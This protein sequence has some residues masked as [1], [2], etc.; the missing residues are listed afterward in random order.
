MAKQT[1]SSGAGTA[2]GTR[3]RRAVG[4]AALSVEERAVLNWTTEQRLA[5]FQRVNPNI[6]K[7]LLENKLL[8]IDSMALDN[9]E[10]LEALR[11]NPKV[12]WEIVRDMFTGGAVD[13]YIS[14]FH[15]LEDVNYPEHFWKVI[16]EN[17]R[18]KLVSTGLT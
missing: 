12:T 13:G 10:I 4:H 14:T 3:K 15:G 6:E 16:I 8:F 2:T 5:A 18:Q 17:E 11:V 1:Q 7:R 9:G